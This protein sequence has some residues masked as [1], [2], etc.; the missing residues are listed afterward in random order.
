M[1]V[2]DVCRI[3]K[4]A[5]GGAL[6]LAGWSNIP[7]GLTIN[8]HFNGMVMAVVTM[9]IAFV[10]SSSIRNPFLLPGSSPTGTNAGLGAAET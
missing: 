10:D 7:A 6:S 9:R 3:N 5:A 1:T 4:P 8:A 2:S